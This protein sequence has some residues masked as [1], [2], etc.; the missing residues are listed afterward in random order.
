MSNPPPT[1]NHPLHPKNEY[2]E[3]SIKYHNLITYSVIIGR[4]GICI[5]YKCIVIK[6]SQLNF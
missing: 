5:A 1:P 3:K 4:D 6:F 2:S